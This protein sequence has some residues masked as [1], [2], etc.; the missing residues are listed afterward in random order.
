MQND[1]PFRVAQ[2]LWNFVVVLVIIVFVIPVQPA[3]MQQH[4]S[5]ISMVAICKLFYC[6]SD[7][8]ALV[9]STT[10]EYYNYLLRITNGSFEPLAPRPSLVSAVRSVSP[11]A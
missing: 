10:T 5:V 11:K 7:F 3:S 8:A 6:D 9:S 4:H 1:G 2:L